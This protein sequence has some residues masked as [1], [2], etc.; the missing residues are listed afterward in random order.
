MKI[1][2]GLRRG[3]FLI[4]TAQLALRGGYISGDLA[5]LKGIAYRQLMGTRPGASA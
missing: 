2:F 3:L 5:L 1:I 4:A